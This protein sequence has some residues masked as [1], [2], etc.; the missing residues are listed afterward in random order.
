M[1][2]VKFDIF[3]DKEDQLFIRNKQL[4]YSHDLRKLYVNL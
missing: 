2:T 1:I 4:N 3:P